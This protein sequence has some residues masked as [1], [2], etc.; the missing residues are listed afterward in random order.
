MAGLLAATAGSAHADDAGLIGGRIRIVAP[1]GTFSPKDVSSRTD[2]GPVGVEVRQGWDVVAA[3][4]EED[5]LFL[6]APGPGPWRLEY[7]VFGD[8]AEFMSPWRIETRRGTV[9]C[10]GTLE[11]SVG[12]FEEDLGANQP[13]TRTRFIDDC[14][15]LMPRLRDLSGGREIE[16]RPPA[17]MRDET[18]TWRPGFLDFAYAPRLG[19]TWLV[20]PGAD[21]PL[22][23]LTASF[24][25]PVR[26]FGGASEL[27][28]LAEA[29]FMN[30]PTSHFAAG[31]GMGF[32]DLV[33]GHVGVGFEAGPPSARR[34]LYFVQGRF[35]TYGAGLGLRLQLSD[36]AGPAFGVFLDVSPLYVVGALL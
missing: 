26:R 17:E 22:F 5:G 28:L 24:V 11:I 16:A 31:I 2:Q 25:L 18:P 15:A 1:N 35:G 13:T 7:V 10:V 29:V 4:V 21:V 34:R 8:R 6:V 9:A 19:V 27:I 12:K 14:D 36:P 23:P 33:E 30:S 20:P 32:H 3:R